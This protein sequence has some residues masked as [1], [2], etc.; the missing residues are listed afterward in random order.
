MELRKEIGEQAFFTA[1]QNYFA[2]DL[3]KISPPESL[4]DGFEDSCQCDLDDFYS[5]WGVQ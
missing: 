2:N 3:Y 1:L 5:E 4:L